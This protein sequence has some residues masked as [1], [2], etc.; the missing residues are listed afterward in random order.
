MSI[1]KHPVFKDYVVKTRGKPTLAP[2][3]DKRPS[4][5][6]DA[7]AEFDDLGGNGS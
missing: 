5:S 4:L 3:D 6:V 1:K 7:A 2:G